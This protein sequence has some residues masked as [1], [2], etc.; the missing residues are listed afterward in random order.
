MTIFSDVV[1][2]IAGIH[3]AVIGKV[4]SSRNSGALDVVSYPDC[5]GFTATA[6]TDYIQRSC[7]KGSGSSRKRLSA[8][9][10]AVRTFLS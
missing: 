7:A 9:L 6:W 4:K 2:W 3:L 10:A 8:Y 1:N 5:S